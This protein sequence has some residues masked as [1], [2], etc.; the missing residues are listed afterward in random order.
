MRF[1]SPHYHA[2]AVFT[3]EAGTNTLCAIGNARRWHNGRCVPPTAAFGIPGGTTGTQE[4]STPSRERWAAAALAAA[5]TLATAPTVLEP[6]L[7][8][9]RRKYLKAVLLARTR[10][11]EE[12]AWEGFYF[13]L[14]F[15]A[16]S[17]KPFELPETEASALIAAFRRLVRDLRAAARR[18]QEH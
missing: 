3:S 10:A 14:V 2:Q 11:A 15:P 17:R 7:E 18:E 8:R 4:G 16:T 9:F 13:W 12:R 1:N 5:P 6:V